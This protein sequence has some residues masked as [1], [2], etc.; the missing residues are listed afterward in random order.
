MF[1]ALRVS[2][3]SARK[4]LD[5]R[6]ALEVSEGWAKVREEAYERAL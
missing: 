5:V 3:Q 4:R 2:E 1:S 6:D